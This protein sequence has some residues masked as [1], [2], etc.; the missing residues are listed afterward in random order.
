MRRIREEVERAQKKAEYSIELNRKSKHL[1]IIQTKELQQ[2]THSIRFMTPFS[3]VTETHSKKSSR[4][5]AFSEDSYAIYRLMNDLCSLLDENQGSTKN[6]YS[7][8]KERMDKLLGVK[9]SSERTVKKAK[10]TNEEEMNKQRKKMKQEI[11]SPSK[12]SENNEEANQ[13]LPS[14]TTELQTP[15]V[16]ILLVFLFS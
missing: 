9:K 7:L 13:L 11:V 4:D 3:T 15:T 16:S 10:R 14:D 5:R 1:E 2:Y 12:N 8:Y 6:V